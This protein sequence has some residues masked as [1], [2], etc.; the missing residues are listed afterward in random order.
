MM[1]L[2]HCA[3]VLLAL[4]GCLEDDIER[5]AAR[6]ESALAEHY[7]KQVA[8]AAM[9]AAQEA[10][11]ACSMAYEKVVGEMLTSFELGCG[12]SCNGLHSERMKTYGCVYSPAAPAAWSCSGA[13]ICESP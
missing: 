8:L 11:D 3:L 10:W 12:Q 9:V 13:A 7:E 1:R 5:A 6:C 4:A 2:M